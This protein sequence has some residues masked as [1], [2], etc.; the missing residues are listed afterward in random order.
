MGAIWKVRV[1]ARDGA[2]RRRG[3]RPGRRAPL[4]SWFQAFNDMQI[5]TI[6]EEHWLVLDDNDGNIYNG[7][8]HFAQIDGGFKDQGFPGYV[9]P[10]FTIAHTPVT[11]VNS[12][13][14]VSIQCT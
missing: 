11:L 8:P 10:L 4:V 7:T 14:P 13:G 12:E 6:I 3:R 9:P 2:R 1:A 5:K